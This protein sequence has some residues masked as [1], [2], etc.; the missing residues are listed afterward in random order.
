MSSSDNVDVMQKKKDETPVIWR[1]YEALRDHLTR[2]FNNQ[3][4]T[5]HND[6]QGVELKLDETDATVKGLQTAVTTM[7]TELHTLTEAVNN[8]RLAIEQPRQEDSDDADSVHNNDDQLVNGRGRGIGQGRGRGF[9]PIQPRR[10]A[11]PQQEDDPLGKPRFSIPSFDGQGDVEDYLT[12]ELKIEKLWRLHDY[13][14]D[15][16]VKLAS[17]EFDGYALRWWDSTVQSRREDNDVPI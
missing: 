13:T 9:A 3:H 5:L 12:W 15:R 14:E 6:V 4:E 1:E 7:Q 11:Q 17:S 16:K 2:T 8:L 10:V